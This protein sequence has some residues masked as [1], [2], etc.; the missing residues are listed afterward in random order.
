MEVAAVRRERRFSADEAPDDHVEGVDDRH[1]EH[2]QD[3]G[4]LCRTEDREH[5]EHRA[6]ERHPGGPEEQLRRVEVEDQKAA[7]RAGERE[8]H[9]RDERLVHGGQERRRA[10]G[11]RGDPGHAGREAIQ[12][13]DEVQRVVHADDPKDGEADPDRRGKRD[14]AV[15]AGI[16]HEVDADARGDDDR[17]YYEIPKEL[18]A[19]AKIER[20]VEQT[21]AEAE[22][23]GERGEGEARRADLLGDEERMTGHAIDEPEREDRDAEGRRDRETADAGDRGGML[24][25]PSRHVEEAEA[26]RKRADRGARADREDER[27]QRG[28]DEQ[29]RR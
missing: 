21:D 27:E 8:V 5:R 11:H 7:D 9:P 12:A 28:S 18:P 13:I 29:D 26:P 6:H 24:A 25:P 17:R 16:V 1:A 23:R 3:G 14:Q 10:E 22:R 20:V 15:A 4:D 2:E 19:R